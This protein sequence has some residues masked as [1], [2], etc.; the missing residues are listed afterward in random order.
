LLKGA[1]EGWPVISQVM[2]L[3]VKDEFDQRDKYLRENIEV[4][5]KRMGEMQA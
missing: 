2:R 5:A 1:R 3:V 4:L